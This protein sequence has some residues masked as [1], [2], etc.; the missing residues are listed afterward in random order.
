M[1]SGSTVSRI[2][3]YGLLIAILIFSLPASRVVG[4]PVAQRA[5]SNG[6]TLVVLS[7][8]DAITLDPMLSLDGQSPLLWRASYESLLSY[9]GPKLGYK[10]LLAQSWS[11]TN[12]GRTYVFRLRS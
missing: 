9:D 5:H 11:V 4:A 8:A 7:G 6:S 2:V 3:G 1:G 12:D 10:P